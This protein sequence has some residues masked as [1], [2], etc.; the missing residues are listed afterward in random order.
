M[1]HFFRTIGLA[2]LVLSLSACSFTTNIK[3]GSSKSSPAGEITLNAVEKQIDRI[4]GKWNGH[5]AEGLGEEYT[6]DGL[7]ILG[8]QDLAL[9]GRDAIVENFGAVFGEGSPFK[10]ATANITT[11]YV[12]DLGNGYAVSDG[13]FEVFGSDGASM[14]IGKWGDVMK[15]TAEG[16]RMLQEAVFAT[17]T[18]A[19]NITPP[20]GDNAHAGLKSVTNDPAM[21]EIVKSFEESWATG[22]S[23]ALANLFTDDAVRLVDSAPDALRGRDAI[24]ESFAA[25][26]A[27]DSP[28]KGSRLTGIVL[29]MRDLDD[30]YLIA[31]GIWRGVDAS[32][33]PLGRGQW[34]NLYRREGGKIRIVMENAGAMVFQGE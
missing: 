2:C 14:M 10:G 21:M 19:D 8:S 32:G 33:A 16:P 26:F 1:T 22:N 29:G 28:F 24:R 30:D 6:A 15:A 27:D 34:A 12:K 7:S 5:D 23:E 31:H 13:T 25:G 9:I 11:E 18:E 20:A 3:F 4:R 17:L